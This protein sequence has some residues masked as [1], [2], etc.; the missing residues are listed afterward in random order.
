MKRKR[1]ATS[2]QPTDMRVEKDVS[3]GLAA[4]TARP[5]DKR[6][7]KLKMPHERD[8]S[9]HAPAPPNDVT[10]QAAQDIEQGRKDTDRYGAAGENFDRK[11]RGGT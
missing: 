8:E 3:T 6:Y 1:P 2:Q 10:E 11:E 5:A 7:V 9:T 4:R